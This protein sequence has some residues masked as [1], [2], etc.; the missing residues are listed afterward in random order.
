MSNQTP[1]WQSNLTGEALKIA[2]LDHSPIRVMA[3]PGTGKTYALMNRVA[4]QR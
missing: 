1:K 2:T 4:R 3:G